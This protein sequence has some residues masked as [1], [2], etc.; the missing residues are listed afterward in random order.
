MICN[1]AKSRKYQLYTDQ[2]HYCKQHLILK[3]AQPLELEGGGEND[4]YHLQ[5]LI[6]QQ[7]FL[8]YFCQEL[9]LYLP[10]IF[11]NCYVTLL[12][13][14]KTT[15]LDNIPPMEV[16]WCSDY[17]KLFFWC[18]GLNLKIQFDEL[19]EKSLL[20]YFAYAS[21]IDRQAWLILFNI[22][23]QLVCR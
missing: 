20:Y 7:Q 13:Y 22:I 12:P 2:V 3:V 6:S 23:Y 9:V 21:A 10:G 5:V 8:L 11:Y 19:S 1:F 15:S 14:T 18:E 4:I 16:R 17:T